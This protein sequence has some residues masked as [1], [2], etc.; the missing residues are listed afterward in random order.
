[1]T[2]WTRVVVILLQGDVQGARHMELVRLALASAGQSGKQIVTDLSRVHYM[3][4]NLLAELLEPEHHGVSRPW[5]AGPLNEPAQR[6]FDLTHATSMFRIFPA[7]PDA[8]QAAR[9]RP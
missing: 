7:L 5:I 9:P 8:V 4:L 2:E 3:N 1:M 6:L